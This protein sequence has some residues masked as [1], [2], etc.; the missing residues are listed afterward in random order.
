ME[1]SESIQ[2]VDDPR[3]ALVF[4]PSQQTI[5]PKPEVPNASTSSSFPSLQGR[6]NEDLVIN[7]ETGEVKSK[8][9]VGVQAVRDFLSKIK[10]LPRADLETMKK[11]KM[12]FDALQ[13]TLLEKIII[14]RNELIAKKKKEI[15]DAKAKLE[16]EAKEEAEA[17]EARK[18]KEG[19]EDA[20]ECDSDE[21]GQETDEE[22]IPEKIVYKTV[23]VNRYLVTDC[24]GDADPNDVSLILIT[25]FPQ[26]LKNLFIGITFRV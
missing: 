9:K 4:G 25:A 20:A 10:N 16:D 18:V 14:K 7:L 3:I 23:D 13:R 15:E 22:S 12:T 2:F 6:D 17:E 1:T 11:R 19:F 5:K 24:G 26:K 8:R 21:E